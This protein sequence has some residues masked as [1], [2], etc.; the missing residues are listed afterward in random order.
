MK[1]HRP[2]PFS[3]FVLFMSINH[4]ITIKTIA[5][6]IKSNWMLI[7]LLAIPF[8]NPIVV[9]AEPQ[10]GLLSGAWQLQEARAEGQLTHTLLF[11]GQY[12]SWTV[13]QSETGAFLRT[14]GGSWQLRGEK[15]R[16][17]YEFD[18]ADSTRVGMAEEWILEFKDAK[19]FLEG[20][21]SP[22]EAWRALDA[23][24]STALSGPWLFSGREREG[25]ITRRDTDQPRKTM[26]MLTG[27]RFQ[28]IAYNTETKQ[29]FGTGGGTYTATDGTYTERIEFFSRDNAR[30]GAELQFE[31]SVDGSDWH[32][33]G[34]STAGEPMHEIWSKRE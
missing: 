10:K 23:G 6:M 26:K 17:A 8:L 31:F 3:R 9:T 25:E 21:G 30:V 13:Y 1:T 20:G 22:S 5:E 7:L 2:E 4:S 29:F 34:K 18:S 15:M 24:A 28:W 16:V 32:H 11:S 33:R 27:T 14:K 12:F 19:L